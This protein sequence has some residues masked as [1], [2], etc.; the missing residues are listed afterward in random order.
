MDTYEAQWGAT[1]FL[2]KLEQIERNPD[3]TERRW[4]AQ[5]AWAGKK[6]IDGFLRMVHD[7]IQKSR[8]AYQQPDT[9]G[10]SRRG[11]GL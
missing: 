3:D 2:E 9:S 11:P 1:R 4:H 8:R 7:E 5:Q 6:A 10:P